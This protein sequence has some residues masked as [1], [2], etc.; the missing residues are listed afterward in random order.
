VRLLGFKVRPPHYAS[1]TSVF[2]FC[3]I[4]IAIL[5]A[6]LLLFL[7]RESQSVSMLS[8]VVK[9]IPAGMVF[10]LIMML[11]NIDNKKSF[12]LTPWEDI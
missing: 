2:V 9:S 11:M 8:I 4:Y 3:S 5:I 7:Q 10:G 12:K 1:A 6:A